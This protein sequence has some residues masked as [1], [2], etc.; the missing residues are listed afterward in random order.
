ML[1]LEGLDDICER[2]QSA[3]AQRTVTVCNAFLQYCICCTLCLSNSV[4]SC[5]MHEAYSGMFSLAEKARKHLAV[6]E[7]LHPDAL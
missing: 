1:H 4:V 3:L 7:A 2:P 5:S 6:H